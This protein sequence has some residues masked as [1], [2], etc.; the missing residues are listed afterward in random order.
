MYHA[1]MR[2]E[3]LHAVLIG[4]GLWFCATT[5]AHACDCAGPSDPFVELV[6]AEQVF[7]AKVLHELPT[8]Q[9]FDVWAVKPLR[10]W[11]GTK[12]GDRSPVYSV[13]FCGANI[14]AGTSYLF[15]TYKDVLGPRTVMRCSRVISRHEIGE[16]L[17]EIGEPIEVE[18][19]TSSPD[20]DPP[21]SY[22]LRTPSRPP[23]PPPSCGVKN[24]EHGSSN[25]MMLVLAA[26]AALAGL[27]RR[28]AAHP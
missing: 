26:V 27:R 25:A 12:L 22:T 28:H 17:L 14:E 24:H 15:Y 8:A 10:I 13:K 9:G 18:D 2:A 11:K 4:T 3:W 1:V 7:E 21:D 20:P 23:C 16:D 5:Q 6:R 19:R